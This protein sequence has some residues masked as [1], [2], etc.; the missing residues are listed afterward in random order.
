[1]LAIESQSSWNDIFSDESFVHDFQKN[2]L[3]NYVLGK[4]WYGG[5]SSTIKRVAIKHLSKLEKNQDVFFFVFFD[6]VFEEA[7]IQSYVLP[8]AIADTEFIVEK[9]AHIC[10]IKTKQFSGSLFDAVYHQIFRQCLFENFISENKI[11][12]ETIL[13]N[14]EKSK[15][16][17]AAYY[18]FSSLLNAEQSNT[19]IVFNNKFIVKVFRRTYLEQN[20]DAEVC[21]FLTEK[22]GFEY[23]PKY[24]G[25]INAIIRN[26]Y[27]VSMALMQKLV[28]VTGDAWE[29][30]LQQTYEI[31]DNYKNKPFELDFVAENKLF[32]IEAIEKHLEIIPQILGSPFY[33]FIENLA[34]YTAKMHVALGSEIQDLQFTRAIYNPDHSVWL[35]NKL[36]YLL[37]NRANLVENNFNKLS[38][39]SADLAKLFLQRKSEIRD[40]FL[41]LNENLLNGRR[42]R[43]HGDYHLGQVLL[44]G[45]EIYIIDFEGEPESTIHDR[46]V[47]QTPLKDVAG[48]L[49]SFH[50]ALYAT[51][52]NHEDFW[53]S[54][55][56][57]LFDFAEKIYVIITSLFMKKYIEHVQ[58]HDLDI[59]YQNEIIYLIKYC[60][61]EKAVYEMGYEL[62]ARPDWVIIP[63]KGLMNTLNSFQK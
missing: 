1:M 48:M 62:N 41:A 60:M 56:K 57:I 21:E 10:K 36:L 6:I 18:E 38:G 3:P 47:K 24:C 32:S 35:K 44:C 28:P 51:I 61:L 25:K 50:Y 33:S 49:R 58:K 31:F 55:R 16:L 59:G 8:I 20:P 22:K 39:L 12:A 63:L 11:F 40:T 29:Y 17:D 42:I 23:T 15:F 46:K 7:F 14:F 45:E 54:E 19:S 27:T 2:I 52:F 5:K 30:T 43:I 4:R 34:E 26:K 37:D 9:N 13:L 53:Q